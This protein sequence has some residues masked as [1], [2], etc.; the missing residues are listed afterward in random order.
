MTLKT[1]VCA[2]LAEKSHRKRQPRTAI[3]RKVDAGRGVRGLAQ[4]LAIGAS[5]VEKLLQV[6][7][8]TTTK[9]V[10]VPANAVR[11]AS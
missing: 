7:L 5:R 8:S 11:A 4:P 3:E 1:Q 2:M 10:S 6:D 9:K